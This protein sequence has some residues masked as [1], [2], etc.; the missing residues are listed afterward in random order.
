MNAGFAEEHGRPRLLSSK[1]APVGAVG[2][3]AGEWEPGDGS[4]TTDKGYK[5]DANLRA[6]RP[7]SPACDWGGGGPTRGQR[8][9]AEV[10][11][12]GAGSKSPTQEMG[13]RTG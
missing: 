9:E 4:G 5:R 10:E 13:A 2:Q 6:S 8:P 3:G 12:K 11:L 7:P 1:G